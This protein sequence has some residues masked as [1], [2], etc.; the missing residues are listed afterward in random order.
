M[1]YLGADN[2]IVYILTDNGREEEIFLKDLSIRNVIN[3]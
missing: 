1:N 3:N 2:H